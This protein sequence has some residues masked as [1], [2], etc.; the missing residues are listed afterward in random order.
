MDELKEILKRVRMALGEEDY[1]VINA[2][3]ETLSYLTHLAKDKQAAEIYRILGS[4]KS[5]KTLKIL[6]VLQMESA[7][8]SDVADD[9]G[10]SD[11]STETSEPSSAP[12]SQSRTAGKKKVKGHGRNG[13][14]DYTGA[15]Q[16]LVS[17]E[18]MKV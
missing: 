1:K 13:A 6:R 5:E 8:D 12:D 3:V 15:R 14:D 4:S 7:T 11:T 18:S 2:V 17:L 10:R 16:I 9:R